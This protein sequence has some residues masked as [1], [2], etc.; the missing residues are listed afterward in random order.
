MTSADVL[1]DGYDRIQGSVHEAVRGLEPEQLEFRLDPQANT[2]AWLT[3]HLSRVQ[4]DH[5]AGAAGTEQAWLAEGWRDRF[6]LPFDAADIG[7]GHSSD[8]VAQVRAPASL[9]LGYQDAVHERTVRYVRTLTDADLDEVIDA[10]WTPPVTRGVR[11]VSVLA[12][13]LQHAGQAAFIRG[14]L[15][16]R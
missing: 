3:W 11:L 2:I 4:D 14:V 1:V 9:L 5:L 13:G 12:D 6:E 15:E 10:D 8:Q 7:Y 16:R